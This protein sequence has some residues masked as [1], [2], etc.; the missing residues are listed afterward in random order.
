MNDEFKVPNDEELVIYRD[1]IILFG[2]WNRGGYGRL[3]IKFGQERKEM[4]NTKFLWE[5][6][7]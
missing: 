6:E 2:H 5:N 3:L 1:L 7:L 4:Q